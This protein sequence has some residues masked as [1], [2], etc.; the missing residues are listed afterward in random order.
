MRRIIL[1]VA[2]GFLTFSLWTEWQKMQHPKVAAPA[3]VA[4][5]PSSNDLAAAAA[6]SIAKPV[7]GRQPLSQA[8]DLITLEN[9]VVR[10]QVD[11]LGG[12]IVAVHL[13]QYPERLGQA[14]RVQLLSSS[15]NAQYL[16]QSGVISSESPELS[17]GAVRRYQLIS[18]STRLQPG[19]KTLTVAF[20][21]RNP[22][23]VSVVK[24]FV[25]TRGQYA[26]RVSH[27]IV[28]HSEQPWLGHLYVQLQKEGVAIKRGLR[29]HTY[30]GPAIYTPEKPYQKYAYAKLKKEEL[31]R[32]IVGGWLAVQQRYFLVSWIPEHQDNN[33]YYGRLSADHNHLMLGAVGPGLTLKPGEEKT[34]T[35]TLYAGPERVALLKPLAPGLELTVDYGWLWMVSSLI[36]SVMAA[37]HR[38]L[39][40]WGWSIVLV[41]VLIK[42]LFYKLS[43]RSIR[44]MAKMRALQPKLERLRTR[45]GDDKQKLSQAT[46]ALYRDEGVNPL[47]GCLPIIIQIPVFI[48]LYYVLIES[49]ELRQSPFIFWIQDLSVKDPLYVL[50]ILMG[51]SMFFQQKLNPAPADPAQAKV[52]M[53]LPVIFTVMFIS[54]PS[55]LVLY[56][57]VNNCLT[58]LQQ[59]WVTRRIQH[60]QR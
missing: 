43:A 39:G 15:P 18:K 47:G 6:N 30:T 13:K 3:V 11:P 1:Y 2:L 40:N 58:L 50:P 57:L 32:N 7:E 51:L 16:A 42:A 21:W 37:L 59:W 14:K 23:G 12:H 25:L 9:D 4:E 44:S 41:T 22:V 27:Q 35:A 56:W 46:M 45:H 36:F 49:V 29:F 10:L 52:M 28:N 20:K 19:Q 60:S 38:W 54:F 17:K 26:I 48:A 24:R 31:N 8:A 55:G 33:H 5:Q 53:L 34:V